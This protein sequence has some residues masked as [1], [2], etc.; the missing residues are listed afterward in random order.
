MKEKKFTIILLHYKQP[1]LIYFAIDS[2]LSQKYSNI[3]LIIC[4]DGSNLNYKKIEKYITKKNNGNI[5]DLKFILNETNIGTVKITNK[6]LHQATGEYILIFAADDVLYN[7]NVISKYVKSFKENDSY[8]VITSQALMYDYELKKLF[9]KYI[10][11]PKALKANNYSTREQFKMLCSDCVYAAGAT[12]YKKE[13]FEKS[14][15]LCED[16]LLVEDWSFWLKICRNGFKIHF[17]NFYGLKHRDGG[18]S[19]SDNK[20]KKIS[21]NVCKYYYDLALININEI[22]P[23]LKLHNIFEKIKILNKYHNIIFHLKINAPEMVDEKILAPKLYSSNPE[24]FLYKVLL[25]FKTLFLKCFKKIKR[26][27]KF[28]LK[29]YFKYILW[30]CFNLLTVYFIEK[31]NLIFILLNYYVSEL[32]FKVL[33][34]VY[35]RIRRN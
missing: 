31:N 7:S 24:Y 34:R 25:K 29:N 32:I 20:T 26:L 22:F 15:Y 13:V 27:T 16:Y 17:I 11:V 5:K 4:D 19:K 14:N 35:K 1:K 28:L 8:A 3:E 12:A 9:G 2:V 30:F 6:A 18:I 23:Y 10:N 33:I 21:K